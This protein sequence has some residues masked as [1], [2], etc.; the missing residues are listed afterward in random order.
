M[1]ELKVPGATLGYTVRG[2]GPVLLM[3]PGGPAG[4]DV[5][6][7]LAERMAGT[8][9]V[10]T[11][12]PRGMYRSSVDDDAAEGGIAVQSDDVHRL[13]AACTSEPAYVLGNSGGA[14]VG[15]DLVARHGEQVRTLVAHEPP[16]TALL[17]DADALRASAGEVEAAYRQGGVWA[18]M[19][20][21]MAHAGLEPPAGDSGPPAEPSPEQRAAM[22]RFQRAAERFL[23]HMLLPTA[24]Y[25]PD[26]DALRAAPGR[27][28]VAVG[29]ESRGQFA[30]RAGVALAER[31][32]T[33]T[34]T[35]PGDHGGFTSRPDAFAA[36]LR[37][38]LGA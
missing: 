1:N 7:E 29:E 14:I 25:V 24:D 11:Y 19:Q 21:F 26:L 18:G 12:D 37:A 8:H 9:T 38:T 5:F 16:L 30:H 15:L 4:G 33:E 34:L 20:R 35:F 10:V 13:L 2:S 31:L 17:E 36:R 6:A 32:G 3:I 28:L 27:T 23:A 22:A